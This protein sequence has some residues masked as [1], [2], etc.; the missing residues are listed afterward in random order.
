M[1]RLVLGDLHGPDDGENRF[2]RPIRLRDR[3]LLG[4]LA[5]S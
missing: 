3:Y 2:C 4:S 1:K 5:S